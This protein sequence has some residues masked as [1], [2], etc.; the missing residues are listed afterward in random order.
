MGGVGKG[1][2][3]Y[4]LAPQLHGRPHLLRIHQT[5]ALLIHFIGMDVAFFGGLRAASQIPKGS[6]SLPCMAGLHFGNCLALPWR[7]LSFSEVKGAWVLPCALGGLGAATAAVLPLPCALGRL[8]GG[9]AAGR[10]C[11]VRLGA[12]GWCRCRVPLLCALVFGIVYVFL[13]SKRAVI[14]RRAFG[15]QQAKTWT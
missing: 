8:G 7:K 4:T 13:F 14:L 10:C 9:T 6:K 2:I 12:G 15:P 3:S 11:C 1:L 5:I